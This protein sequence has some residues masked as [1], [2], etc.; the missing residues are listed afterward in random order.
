MIMLIRCLITFAILFASQHSAADAK[1]KIDTEFFELNVQLGVINVQDY[2]SNFAYGIGGTFKT[3]EDFFLQFNYLQSDV[4][5][6]SLE[7]GGQGAND[8]DRDYTHYNIAIGYNIFQGEVFRGSQSNLSSFY[9]IAGLGHTSFIRES[10]FTYVVGMGYQLALSR[11]YTAAIE[12]RSHFYKTAIIAASEE[13]SF[14]NS[15][16][17]LSLGWLF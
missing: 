5:L 4:G 9:A 6:S 11:R 12:Y 8:T 16:L 17:S 2:T 7:E 13:K 3:T 1:P 14:H 10:N 15:Q